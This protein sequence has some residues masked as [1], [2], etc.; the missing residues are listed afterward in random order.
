MNADKKAEK[1][2]DYFMVAS[3]MVKGKMKSK[4]MMAMVKSIPTKLEGPVKFPS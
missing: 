1:I 4:K 3:N 2:V